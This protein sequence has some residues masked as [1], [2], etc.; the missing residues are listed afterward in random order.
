MIIMIIKVESQDLLVIAGE[1]Q[2]CCDQLD[3]TDGADD[4]SEIGY[5]TGEIRHLADDL[6]SIAS[7]QETKA[8]K[9]G[10]S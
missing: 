10:Y 9:G 2:R 3:Y 8:T 6:Q 4:D 1:I 5:L 7:L